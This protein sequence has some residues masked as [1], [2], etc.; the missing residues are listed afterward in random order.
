MGDLWDGTLAAVFGGI[1]GALAGV[2][3]TA[4]TNKTNRAATR[5]EKRIDDIEAIAELL[6]V[7]ALAY[8]S[9]SSTGDEA[10]SRK[11]INLWETLVSRVSVLAGFE[12]QV[13]D[14]TKVNDYVDQLYELITGSDFQAKVRS[15][16]QNKV[17]EIR[18]LCV[19]LCGELHTSR[20]LVNRYRHFWKRLPWTFKKQGSVER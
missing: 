17:A 6:R 7:E 16:D 3:S 15:A 1:A 2:A 18:N 20:G 14:L 11:I 8:W 4:L 12:N 13:G 9:T 5:V 10:S 19:T